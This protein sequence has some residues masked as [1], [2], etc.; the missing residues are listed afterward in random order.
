[1]LPTLL[2]LASF[3]PSFPD[4]SQRTESAPPS[5]EITALLERVAAPH[6]PL[7]IVYEGTW[8]LEGHFAKPHAVMT[9]GTRLTVLEG[10]GDRARLDWATWET[11]HEKEADVETTLFDGA[12]V[13]YRGDA[14]SPFQEKSG[15]AAA[16]QRARLEAVLPWCLLQ[17]VRADAGHC[18]SS[19]KDACVWSEPGQPAG[20]TREIA[21]NST[22]KR[23]AKVTRTFAHPRF[24]DARDETV[25]GA[26][27]EQDG[28]A[29]PASLTLRDVGGDDPLVSSPTAFDVRLARVETNVDVAHELDVPSD[30]HAAPVKPAR[31]TSTIQVQELEPG[32]LSFASKSC[33]ACTIVAEFRDHLVAIGAPLSSELGEHIVEAIHARFPS[34]PIRYVLFGHYH[35]HYTGGLRAFLAAGATVVAPELGL[36]FAREI[37]ARPFTIAPDAWARSSAKPRFE[38][39]QGSRVFEDES[40]RLDAI[41][42]GAASHHTDEYVVF[43]LPRTQVLLQDDIGWSANGEGKLFFG[44]RSRGLRDAIVERKL[45]V[46]KLWQGWPVASSRPS[47]SFEELDAGV[48]SAR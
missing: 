42:I 21:W 12:R 22:T 7:R 24:G 15:L 48:R 27:S 13:L 46:Q 30:V 9:F 6:T 43:H 10:P 32:I 23:L 16:R 1:M 17:R 31:D 3:V 19:G 14:E 29:V 20:S 11:G 8:S 36:K 34:K 47:I 5:S 39:F 38:S 40:Q 18:I 26:W 41:D 28:V 33:D 45:A 44:P 25:Y 35:P 2:V 37:A 4:A